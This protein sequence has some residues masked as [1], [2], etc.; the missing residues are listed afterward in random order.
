LRR[1]HHW[2]EYKIP[3]FP[4]RPFGVHT[5]YNNETLEFKTIPYHAQCFHENDARIK[6]FKAN[7]PRITKK[8]KA[9][10]SRFGSKLTFDSTITWRKSRFSSLEPLGEVVKMR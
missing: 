3:I 5:S 6:R 2:R 7:T 9:R 1:P 10:A 8:S 4:K